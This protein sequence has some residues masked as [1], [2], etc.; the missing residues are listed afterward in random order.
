MTDRARRLL[1]FLAGRAFPAAL[2]AV[3]LS[4]CATSYSQCL[5]NGGGAFRC[6]VSSG[7]IN[8]RA[9]ANALA[10][11][12]AGN[13][14][15]CRKACGQTRDPEICDTWFTIKCPTD[16][17]VCQSACRLTHDRVACRGACEAGD[18]TACDD[19]FQMVQ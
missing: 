3:V 12:S 5:H 6:T 18:Q 4:S 10:L 7:K 8:Q 9:N 11:C 17:A 19:Y 14:E 1:C 13:E 2:V 16:A 15:I